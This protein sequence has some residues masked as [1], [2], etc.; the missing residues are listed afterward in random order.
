LK[1]KLLKS[2]DKIFNNAVNSKL[3]NLNE[4]NATLDN[5]ETKYYLGEN[6]SDVIDSILDL[7][8]DFTNWSSETKELVKSYDVN[9]EYLDFESKQ[10]IEDEKMIQNY[11]SN[12]KIKKG[13]LKNDVMKYLLSS[14]IPCFD[15]MISESGCLWISTVDGSENPE[16]IGKLLVNKF[17]QEYNFGCVT[18][19]DANQ[20]ELG[21]YSR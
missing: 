5:L 12:L 8:N 20:K 21:R 14:R 1:T 4:L 19:F 7:E 10:K 9:N 13:N 17:G 11:R 6:I 2:N 3:A 18:V 16:T 15:A